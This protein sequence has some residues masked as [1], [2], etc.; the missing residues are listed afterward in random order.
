[1][2]ILRVVIGCIVGG[3]VGYFILYKKIG[4]TTGTCPITH[5]PYTSTI[6]GAIIGALLSGGL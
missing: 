4:C 1:M 6:Y 3:L 5:S 2:K